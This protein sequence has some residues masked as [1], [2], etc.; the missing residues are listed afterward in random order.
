MEDS[1]GFGV[2][3]RHLRGTLTAHEIA[4]YVALSWRVD[5]GGRCWPSLAVL[6]Q[7]A[8]CSVATVKRALVS[9]EDKELISRRRRRKG[10]RWASTIYTMRVFRKG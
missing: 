7:D 1:A 4:V 10:D 2:V 5:S 6:A 3:P 9:L 8:G